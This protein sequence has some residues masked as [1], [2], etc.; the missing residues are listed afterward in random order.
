MSDDTPL[1]ELYQSSLELINDLLRHKFVINDALAAINLHDIRLRLKLWSM[2]IGRDA[3][4]QIG[5]EKE[6]CK[7]LS[8]TL[9]SR[10]TQ[11][12]VNLN[13]VQNAVN[14][15]TNLRYECKSSQ[16]LQRIVIRLL[17]K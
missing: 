9:R 5:A 12:L 3:L 15:E 11:M 6:G 1:I 14:E 8:N 10:F 13:S 2:D 4:D 16:C 17:P 7:S